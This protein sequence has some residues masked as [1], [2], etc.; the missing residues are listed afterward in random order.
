MRQRYNKFSKNEKT[1]CGFMRCT[2]VISCNTHVRIM[3][4]RCTKQDKTEQ[5]PGKSACLIPATK[6]KR[7]GKK[8][9][10]C[11]RKGKSRT[12]NVPHWDWKKT[13]DGKGERC[14]SHRSALR[15]PSQHAASAIAARCILCP[16][17]LPRFRAT[18]FTLQFSGCKVRADRNR[19]RQAVLFEFRF[20]Q[21]ASSKDI[22]SAL[23]PLFC[24][25]SRKMV[26]TSAFHSLD[27]PPKSTPRPSKS[28]NKA[29]KP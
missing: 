16:I 9:L 4:A 3:R 23:R 21:P 12:G 8:G 25:K 20:R 7:E 27:S 22:P 13:K 18:L 28:M 26:R 5:A 6:V 2:H 29:V 19:L 10:F 14:T 11:W 24:P 1:K 15:R 17:S